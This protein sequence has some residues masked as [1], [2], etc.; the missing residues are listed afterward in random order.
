MHVGVIAT[1]KNGLELFVYRELGVMFRQGV[2]ISL[3]PTKFQHGLYNAH[4]D[5]QVYRWTILKLLWGHLSFLLRRP[6]VYLRVLRE[7]LGVKALVDFSLACYFATQMDDIDVIYAEFGDHKLFAGYFC[8]QLIGKPLAVVI[9]AYELYVNPNFPL[10]ERS[11]AHCDRIITVTEYNK[12]LLVERFGIAA[13]RIEVVRIC[14]DTDDYAPADKFAI[15]IVAFFAE[16]KGHEILFRAVKQLNLPNIEIWVVGSDKVGGAVDLVGLT[17]SLGL[18]DQVAFFGALRG[19]ALKAVYHACDVFCLPSHF[20]HVGIAE[21][22]PTAIAE[23]MAFGKPVVSTRHVEIPRVLDEIVVDERD[24]EG[25]A[26]AL[27]QVYDSP[28]LRARLGAKNRQLALDLFST[29]NVSRTVQILGEIA[30]QPKY[31]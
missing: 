14:V 18:T 1:M 26:A 23:A 31:S 21:G 28:E 16:R 4:P 11:L 30:E 5:W 17:E 3:F 10:F 7:A 19:T 12:D 15:L 6:G 24:V 2:S 25:L 13:D 8:K 22:F 20:D 27:K 9:H 29:A